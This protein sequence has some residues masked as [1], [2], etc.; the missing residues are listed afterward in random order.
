[1]ETILILKITIIVT[2]AFSYLYLGIK[3]SEDCLIKGCQDYKEGKR[4]FVVVA[5]FCQRIIMT[6]CWL[7]WVIIYYIVFV[8]IKSCSS[9]ELSF[10]DFIE[11]TPNDLRL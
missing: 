10:G 2:F 6:V 3:V 9:M 1:M 4:K 11:L 8:V 7:P 5:N